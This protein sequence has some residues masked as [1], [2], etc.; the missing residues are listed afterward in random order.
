[1]R[2]IRNSLD[3]LLTVFDA[4]VPSSTRGRR[5]STN[6]PAQSLA[7]LNDSNVNRWAEAWSRRIMA[8]ASLKDDVAR[9]RRMFGGAF[10]RPPS[11]PELNG[12]LAFVKAIASGGDAAEKELAAAEEEA[13]AVQRRIDAMLGPA[14]E[15]LEQKA[16]SLQT[17]AVVSKSAP[18]PFAEWDFKR[19]HEDL[20]GRLN[21]ALQGDA[22]IENGALVLDGGKSYAKSVALTKTLGEKTME[23]WVMLGSLDQRGGGVMTLQDDHGEIFDS[24]VFAEKENACWVPGS[25]NFR[26]SRNLDAPREQDATS[27]I[28]HVAVV[29]AANGTVTAYRDGKPLGSPYQSEGPAKFESGKS[30]VLFGLRHGTSASGNRVLKGRIYRAR[31]YDRAL[32]AEEVALTSRIESSVITEGDVIASLSAGDRDKIAQLQAQSD[33]ARKHLQQLREVERGTGPDF[34]WKSFAQSL[35]NLK[36]FIY[37]R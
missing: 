15:K 26:R 7:L 32:S 17:R 27:R 14:R 23:A 34:A 5:D 9:V 29:Y 8:D 31:L 1:V 37:L 24:I 2:V 22:R 12:S 28:V 6:V 30:E 35:F 21:L 13:R 20:R 4:P 11:G 33:E 10:G 16:K 36:E 25:N 18:E 19:G 3:P